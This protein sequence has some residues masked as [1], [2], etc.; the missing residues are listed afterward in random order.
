MAIM[1]R[2]PHTPQT[3]VEVNTY[4]EKQANH[5][6]RADQDT[7]GNHQVKQSGRDRDFRVE[8]IS[9]KAVEEGNCDKR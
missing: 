2:I 4:L 7:D 8:K 6:D 5:C 9:S 1:V 3:A